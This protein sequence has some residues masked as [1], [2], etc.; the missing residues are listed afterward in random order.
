MA[1]PRVPRAD[2]SWF[3]PIKAQNKKITAPSFKKNGVPINASLQAAD[4]HGY[5]L[6]Y[7]RTKPGGGSIPAAFSF[8]Y[9]GTGPYATLKFGET[10]SDRITWVKGPSAVTTNKPKVAKR[11]PDKHPLL[12]LTFPPGDGVNTGLRVDPFQ[13]RG[14][15][16][17]R[18]SNQRSSSAPVDPGNRNQRAR[19]K[20]APSRTNPK[21]HQ[22]PKRT[23]TKGKTISQVFGKRTPGGANV[24]SAD[25]EKA[26]FTDPRLMCLMRHTPGTQE[27]LL[28]G[29]LD[30]DIQPEGVYIK[31][32]YTTQV[33]RDSAEYD[34]V[35]AALNS[36]VNQK[37]DADNLPSQKPKSTKPKPKKE[38]KERAPPKQQQKE[39]KQ[40]PQQESEDTKKIQWAEDDTDFAASFS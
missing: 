2:A 26:G 27:L 30:H 28:A 5:W 38:K 19:S 29:H 12:P 36:V 9:T 25:T 16:M 1:V 14:R 31:F 39:Q 35:I 24:G 33:K 7:N 23:L 22:I 21:T 15:T 10:P 3:Q 11:D 13:N 4:Q 18:G 37:Y 32:T 17:D 6:R 40:E 20:S 34:R 8:Y